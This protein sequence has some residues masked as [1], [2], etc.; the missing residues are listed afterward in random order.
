MSKWEAECFLH[1]IPLFI[2]KWQTWFNYLHLITQI[3]L[4]LSN[5][6]SNLRF[7]HN[8][9]KAIV[10][11]LDL[12]VFIRMVDYVKYVLFYFILEILVLKGLGIS[13]ILSDRED[14]SS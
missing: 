1:I 13:W 2:I 12:Y 9:R 7:R 8:C 10:L 14:L 6:S 4:E 3:L 11:H 5:Q